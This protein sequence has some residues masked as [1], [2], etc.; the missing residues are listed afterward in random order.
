MKQRGYISHAL[1]NLVIQ[2]HDCRFLDTFSA[3]NLQY[4]KHRQ[5]ILTYITYKLPEGV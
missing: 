4:T 1:E 3:S 5:H 2:T